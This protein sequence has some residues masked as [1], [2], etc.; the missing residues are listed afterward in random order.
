[1]AYRRFLEIDTDPLAVER[2]KQAEMFAQ[3]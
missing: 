3:P 1:V 2:L